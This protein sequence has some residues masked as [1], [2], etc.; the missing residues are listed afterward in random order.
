MVRLVRR[1]R[2]ANSGLANGVLYWTALSALSDAHSAIASILLTNVSML[3]A[4]RQ[5]EPLYRNPLAATENT[6]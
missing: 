1:L 2:L 6:Q 4:L 3:V 5:K